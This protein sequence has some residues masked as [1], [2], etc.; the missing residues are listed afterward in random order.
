[1]NQPYVLILYY[2]RHGAVAEM[3]QQVARGVSMLPGIEA[4]LHHRRT[5]SDKWPGGVQYQINFIDGF[6]EC[7]RFAFQ[8][9]D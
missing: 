7:A 9:D 6:L 5:G 4:R 3:A 1:M 8:I 2:S